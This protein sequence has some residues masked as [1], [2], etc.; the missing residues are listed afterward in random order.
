[1]E[2]LKVL[3]SRRMEIMDEVSI[4]Q[5]KRNKEGRRRMEEGGAVRR[6]MCI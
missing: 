1:M 4:T 5:L 2:R 6:S 3:G